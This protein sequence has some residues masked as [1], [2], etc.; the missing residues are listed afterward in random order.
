MEDK[1][2][3]E[4]I[5]ELTAQRDSF[6]NLMGVYKDLSKGRK[7]AKQVVDYI[8]GLE[9]KLNKYKQAI[10]EIEK[11]TSGNYETLDPLA[12]QQIR[13]IINKTKD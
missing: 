13:S 7:D 12:K 9:A 5:E 8:N 3:Q 6:M 2:P 11:I 10:D 1:K 4:R